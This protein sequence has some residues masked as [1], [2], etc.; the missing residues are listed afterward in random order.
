MHDYDTETKIRQ[1]QDDRVAAQQYE[2]SYRSMYKANAALN[3]AINNASRNTNNTHTPT[4]PTCT[5]HGGH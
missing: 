5:S 1:D 4:I 3:E 2:D